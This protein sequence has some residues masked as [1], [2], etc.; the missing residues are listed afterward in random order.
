MQVCS[1]CGYRNP[2]LKGFKGL[3]I[4]HWVCPHCG[5]VHDRDGNA[6]ENIRIET[7]RLC[8]CGW[9]E[10]GK[11]K[12]NKPKSPKAKGAPC[13]GGTPGRASG[14]SS[15]GRPGIASGKAPKKLS[16]CEPGIK[17]AVSAKAPKR[18]AS[19]KRKAPSRSSLTLGIL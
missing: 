6:A 5:A 14:E 9:A 18:K 7:I 16:R 2:E 13:T 3:K 1:H 12:S 11:E 4:G 17:A 15:S 10:P 19:E 8:Y